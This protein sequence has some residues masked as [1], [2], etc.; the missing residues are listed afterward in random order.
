[1]DGPVSAEFYKL[2][3]YEEGGFFVGHRDTEKVPGMF[4]TLVVGLPSS[5]AG[6]ELVVRHKGREARLDLHSDDPAEV[7][8]AA[9]YADCV[10]EVL[11]ITEGCRLVLIYNLVR[12]A[13]GRAPEPPDYAAEQ[14]QVTALLRRW[15]RGKRREDDDTPEKLVYPLEHAYTPAELSFAALK[16]AD[17]AV[18]AV[19]AATTREAQCDLHLALLTV[20]ESGAA[21]NLESYGSRRGRWDTEEDEFEAGEVFDR[22]MTLSDWRHPDSDAPALGEIPVEAEE[23]VPPDACDDMEPDEEHFR[24]ATGNEGASFER[25]YRRAALVLWPSDRVF[26]VLSQAGLR[27]A[28]PYLDN[29]VRR[30]TERGGNQKSPLWREAHDLAGHMVAQWPRRDGYAWPNEDPGDAARMLA[31]LTRLDDIDLIERFL[32]EVTAAGVYGKGDNAAIVAALGC[33]PPPRAAALVERIVSGTATSSFGACADLLAR[34]AAALGPQHVSGLARAATGLVAALPEDRARATPD[35]P[36]QRGPEVSPTAV[37]DLLTGLGP[38]DPALADRAVD[39]ILA[40]PRTYGLDAALVPA[41]R[42][43]VGAGRMQGAA[44][45]E[46]LRAAC[47]AHLRARAAEPLAPPADWRRAATLPCR[48]RNC[49][50]LAR[51]LAD[52]ERQTWILKAAEAERSHVEDSIRRAQADLDLATDRRG[53]PYSLVCTKNQASY[54]RR[55]RQ[56]RQDL[57]DLA[58][59]AG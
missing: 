25:T 26:A 29:L 46:R 53:R 4:A 14:A 54:E 33:L 27:V 32:A 22:S 2:L 43:L 13:R 24:E 18:A 11:P 7:A 12:R 45:V 38:I 19:L 20:E 3:L 5:F 47:V 28:L 1:M 30:W 8:F 10:H 58:L 36:R 57:K 52:P 34:T 55:A 39:H 42:A 15:Q 56:R 21:E 35:E 59:L 6:G 41:A 49:T 17:A 44:S 9:F 48:C 37:V 23:F 50:E 16:G 51:F 31:L 40:Y